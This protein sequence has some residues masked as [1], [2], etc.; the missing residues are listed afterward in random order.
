MGFPINSMITVPARPIAVPP[1]LL[2]PITA[3]LAED[4]AHV[5]ET[6]GILGTL[7]RSIPN[8]TKRQISLYLSIEF[9]S[10]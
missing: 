7:L 5:V 8:N 6:E 3:R 10:S 2:R 1:S 4:M 9:G